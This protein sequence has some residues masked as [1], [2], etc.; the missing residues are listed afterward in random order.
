MRLYHL[1]K[2]VERGQKKS[3]AVLR[4]NKPHKPKEVLMDAVAEGILQERKLLVRR[5]A[6]VRENAQGVLAFY[7]V[8]HKLRLLKIVV[9][10]AALPR[11]VEQSGCVTDT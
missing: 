6:R 8:A 5:D 4:D 2:A 1:H 11:D 3:L 9:K 10:Q 7:V